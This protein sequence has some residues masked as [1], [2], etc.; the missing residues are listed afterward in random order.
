MPSLSASSFFR[1]S[2]RGLA[3]DPAEARFVVLCDDGDRWYPE[4][5]DALREGSGTAELAYSDLRRVDVS[6]GVRAETMWQG[7]RNNHTNLAS[8]LISNTIVGASCLIRRR[9]VERALPF[10][11]GPGWDFHDHWLVLVALSTGEVAYV[12]RPLYD[13][14]KHPGGVLGRVG[15]DDEAPPVK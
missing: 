7:R 9:A 12:D 4:K 1:N 13:Q 2:E 15:A 3:L 8:L 11:S 14:V 10:P 6:R 5:L